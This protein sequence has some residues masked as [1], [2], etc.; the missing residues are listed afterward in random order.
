MLYLERPESSDCGIF[1]VNKIPRVLT[2][3]LKGAMIAGTGPSSNQELP[4]WFIYLLY[5]A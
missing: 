1:W 4:F 2:D 5:I 3:I